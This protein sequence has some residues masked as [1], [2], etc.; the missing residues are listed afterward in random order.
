MAA[1]AAV[2]TDEGDGRMSDGDAMR[3]LAAQVRVS[4]CFRAEPL[5]LV[6]PS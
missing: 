2:V 6:T 3:Q 1:L 5:G 4:V